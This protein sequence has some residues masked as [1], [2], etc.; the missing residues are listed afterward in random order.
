[1]GY[2]LGAAIGGCIANG[3]RQTVLFTSDGSFG[4]NLIELATAVTQELPIVIIVLNNGVL[5]MVRQWQDMFHEQ[6]H[7]QTTLCR[8]T[9]FAAT[10]VSFGAA[11][12]RAENLS[13][14]E[15]ILC[16]LPSR[17]PT[18][19]DCRIDIAEKVL[20]MIPPGGTVRDIIV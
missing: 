11:G 4:M 7:S 16:N 15:K 8:K 9:D 12:F 13:Q 2:G 19:I 14:I 17:L 10:A 18:V 1:M 5:G 20:P 6:R 3:M